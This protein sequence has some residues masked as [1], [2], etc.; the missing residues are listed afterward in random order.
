M[1]I[2]TLR[3]MLWFIKENKTPSGIILISHPDVTA[4]SF[5]REAMPEPAELIA[6]KEE[7]FIARDRYSKNC[8]VPFSSILRIIIDDPL[9]QALISG[10]A[11]KQK[12]N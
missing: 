1:S 2:E 8:V 7:Y 3:D 11:I 5:Y 12:D 4:F 9:P 10:S 6:I